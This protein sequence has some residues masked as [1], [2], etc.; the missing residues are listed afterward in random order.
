MLGEKKNVKQE[1][2]EEEL[3]KPKPEQTDKQE[4]M[5]TIVEAQGSDKTQSNLFYGQ[6]VPS[7][8]SRLEIAK[9]VASIIASLGIV[10]AVI[11]L[12]QADTFEKRRIVLSD[13]S[14]KRRIAIEAV[15]HTRSVDFLKAYRILKVTYH[16]KRVDPKTKESLIDSLN[17]V[18]NMYD[19]IAI[20][21]INDL[22]DRCIIKDNIYFSCIEVATFCDAFS[23][24]ENYRR[25]F[26]TLLALMEQEKCE[27]NNPIT[28][29]SDKGGDS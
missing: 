2:G 7:R 17:Y 15:G 18:M 20:I 21:Y 3:N 24:P 10:I 11:G 8:S 14:E 27:Q 5:K 28:Q 16:A 22:A 12:Y 6:K 1:V 26:D 25:N 9:N 29:E 19:S 23:Y 13:I 4:G